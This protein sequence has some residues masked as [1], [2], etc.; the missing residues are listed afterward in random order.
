MIYEFKFE[1]RDSAFLVF[2]KVRNEYRTKKEPYSSYVRL[3]P[4][5]NVLLAFDSGRDSIIKYAEE[6]SA[7]YFVR[8]FEDLDLLF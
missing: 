5:D 8:E 1:D 3:R 6:C 4:N 2:N 7:K